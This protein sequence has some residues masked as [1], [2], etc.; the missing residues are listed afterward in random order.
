MIKLGKV[1]CGPK[2]NDY[3][4]YV[5]PKLSNE[6]YESAVKTLSNP[7]LQTDASEEFAYRATKKMVTCEGGDHPS[8]CN[9][10]W[11]WEG[12]SEGDQ[13]SHVTAMRRWAQRSQKVFELGISDKGTWRG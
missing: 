8:S 2:P 9:D 11:R 10:D 7:N 13:G 6:G 1:D 12:P 3:V 4:K 5:T